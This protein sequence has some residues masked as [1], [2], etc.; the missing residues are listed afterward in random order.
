MTPA[1]WIETWARIIR[2]IQIGT[3]MLVVG[4]LAG[5]IRGRW[6]ER[7]E[8]GDGPLPKL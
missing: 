7:K 4:F 6:D 5:Y 1:W 2:E 8:D 3:L